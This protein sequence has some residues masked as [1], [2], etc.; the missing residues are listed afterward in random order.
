MTKPL[1]LAIVGA[2]VV[3]TLVVALYPTWERPS[4]LR[5]YGWADKVSGNGVLNGVQR[6]DEFDAKRR[7]FSYYTG[8][9]SGEVGPLTA[10]PTEVLAEAAH[11]SVSVRLL[12]F[13][14]YEHARAAEEALELARIVSAATTSVFPG[15][16]IPVEIDVHFMPEGARFSLA[17]RVDWRDGRPYALAIFAREQKLVR[18]T[19]AHELYHV[20]TARWS[21][22]R[23]PEATRRPNAALSYEEA[24]AELYAACGELL[25][26]AVLPREAPSNDRLTLV[27]P[28]RGDRVFEGVLSGDELV[29]AMDLLRTGA[30]GRGFVGFG[31][32]LAATLFEQVFAGATTITVDSPQGARLLT[33]CK[34]AASDSFAIER[35]LEALG[36][37]A[38]D[39][40]ASQG[41]AR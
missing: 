11:G 22:N 16:A 39:T 20:L 13:D 36:R 35:W 8:A 23:T 28:E 37:G 34:D 1:R 4:V 33:L 3:G 5:E 41:R 24:A 30:G 29:G 26:N 10:A 15:D 14:D 19:P 21:L 9:R 27:D 17:K 32:L 31:P 2:V 6:I 12:G 40:N 38:G 18:S 7:R 25:A